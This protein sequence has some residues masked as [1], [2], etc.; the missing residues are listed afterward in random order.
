MEVIAYIIIINV[1][2]MQWNHRT[3]LFFFI[4]LAHTAF[5]RSM[6]HSLGF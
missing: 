2:I 1:R 6:F 4:N 5:D 3:G